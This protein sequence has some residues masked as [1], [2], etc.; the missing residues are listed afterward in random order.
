MISLHA[1]AEITRP[2]AELIKNKT[3][4]N[5]FFVNQFLKRI[6]ELD[7]LSF[8]FASKCWQWDLKDIKNQDISDNVVDLMVAKMETLPDET[9]NLLRLGACIG[10]VFKLNTLSL[11]SELSVIHSGQES[12]ASG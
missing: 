3:N 9:K 1:E 2:L 4:G 5:P 8:D 6:Y 11:I 7:L 10:N 12:L